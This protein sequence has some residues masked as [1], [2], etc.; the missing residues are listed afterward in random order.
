MRLEA[1]E[2]RRRITSLIPVALVACFMIA[3]CKG[4][5]VYSKADFVEHK[6]PAGM[7]R[8]EDCEVCHEMPYRTWKESSHGDEKKM[9]CARI[10]RQ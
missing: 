6:I 1:K 4:N 7:Q 8:A 3:G 10:P 2:E 5:W 9:A